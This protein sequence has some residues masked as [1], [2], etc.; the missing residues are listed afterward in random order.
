VRG[1]GVVYAFRGSI[2]GQPEHSFVLAGLDNAKH[3]RLHFQD[4]TSPDREATGR[5]LMDAG[6]TVKLHNPLSS[7]LVFLEET[8]GSK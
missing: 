3:Y 2:A 4:G 7:E 8:A 5:E 6:I 1:K